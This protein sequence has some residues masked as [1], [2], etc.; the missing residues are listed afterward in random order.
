MP[1]EGIRGTAPGVAARVAKPE[2]LPRERSCETGETSVIRF[3]S[4][5]PRD[6]NLC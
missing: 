5:M 3:S 2:G 6:R 1:K 4:E